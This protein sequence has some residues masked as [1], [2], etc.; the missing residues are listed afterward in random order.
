[1]TPTFA[2]A[3]WA[4]QMQAQNQL[5]AL[6]PAGK[7]IMVANSTHYIHVDQPQVVIDAIRDVVDA[8]RAGKTSLLPPSK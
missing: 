4:A 6:F 2:N 1:M 5:A 3:L 7:H 8:V